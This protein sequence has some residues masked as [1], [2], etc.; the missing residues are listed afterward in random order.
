MAKQTKKSVKKSAAKHST[1]KEDFKHATLFVSATINLAFFI[2]WLALQVTTQYDA[3]VA[4][5]LFVR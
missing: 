1:V 3:Q 2:G 5:L 4:Q